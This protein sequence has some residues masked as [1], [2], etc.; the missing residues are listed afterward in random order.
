M[1][2]LEEKNPLSF[3]STIS[4][5]RQKKR[6]LVYIK[7]GKVPEANAAPPPF[8]TLRSGMEPTGSTQEYSLI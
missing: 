3:G 7:G 6:I 1:H 8:L 2:D 5:A 4:G